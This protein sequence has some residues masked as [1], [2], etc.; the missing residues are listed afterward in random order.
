MSNTIELDTTKLI[1][2][3]SENELELSQ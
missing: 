3:L 2:G 1:S